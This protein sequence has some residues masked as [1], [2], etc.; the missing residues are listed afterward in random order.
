[1]I[2]EYIEP[3]QGEMLSAKW[4]SSEPIHRQT[5][6]RGLANIL[7]DL[8]RVPLPRIG[9]FTIS[10]IGEVT[11][12]GRPLTAAL[13]SLAADGVSSEIVQILHTHPP[14]PTSMIYYI[15]MTQG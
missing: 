10:D 12:S 2:T 5:L 15:V 9:S 8:I 7:L 1:M 13:A 14:L 11:L 4:P 3:H 6:F